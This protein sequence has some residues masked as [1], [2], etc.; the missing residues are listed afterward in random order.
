MYYVLSTSSHLPLL[1]PQT[2]T[3]PKTNFPVCSRLF[4]F[5]PNYSRLFRFVPFY[6]LR[7]RRHKGVIPGAVLMLAVKGL[8]GIA[9]GV[10]LM[11]AGL[12]LGIVWAVKAS[13]KQGTVGFMARVNALQELNEKEEKPGTVS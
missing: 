10:A 3:H 4:R 1:F 2:Y 13:H 8:L 5:I 9:L 7:V 12:V 6:S 11:V